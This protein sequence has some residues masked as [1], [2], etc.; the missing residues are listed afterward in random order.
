MRRKTLE[1]TGYADF[2]TV[3]ESAGLE[4]VPNRVVSMEEGNDPVPHAFVILS[5]SRWRGTIL[6]ATAEQFYKNSMS[7]KMYAVCPKCERFLQEPSESDAMNTV[8]SHN[9]SRHDG[10]N[11]ALAMRPRLE[12]AERLIQRSQEVLSESELR[13]FRNYVRNNKVMDGFFSW[14]VATMSTT[15]STRTSRS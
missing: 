1:E 8:K 12:D 10:K 4:S 13:A 2:Q 14:S 5:E 9:K 7:E 11:V 3:S 6:D 15:T